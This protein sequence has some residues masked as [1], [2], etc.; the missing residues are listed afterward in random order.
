MTRRE[1]LR[2]AC[3]AYVYLCLGLFVLAI[4][5]LIF[6]IFM[7]NGWAGFGVALGLGMIFLLTFCTAYLDHTGRG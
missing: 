7:L 4:A 2:A 6:S 5:L 3:K 1:L